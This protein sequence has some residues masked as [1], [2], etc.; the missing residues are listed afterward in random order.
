MAI[1]LP[2]VTIKG[3]KGR[4]ARIEIHYSTDAIPGHWVKTEI[5]GPL[6]STKLIY[7]YRSLLVPVFGIYGTTVTEP[8]TYRCKSELLATPL[9]IVRDKT[10]FNVEVTEADL[11][12]SPEEPGLVQSIKVTSE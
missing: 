12:R 6:P 8:G 5:R 11:A 7:K 1:L 2:I 9:G 4:A 3:E 10:E